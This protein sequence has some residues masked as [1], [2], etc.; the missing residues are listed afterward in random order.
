[1]KRRHLLSLPVAALMPAAAAT[2]SPRFLHVGSYAPLGQGLYS[3]GIAPDGGLTSL[4]LTANAHSPSWLV[5]QGRR[6]YAAEEGADQVAVY[7]QDEAGGLQLQQRLASGGQGPVHLALG[8]G[9]AWVAHYGDARFAALPLG[10]DGRL[11]PAESW[12]ACSGADCRPGPVRAQYGP[13]GSNAISGHDAPHAHMVQ[14]SVDG[15]WLL[16]TDLGRDRLLVWPLTPGTPQGPALELALSPGSGPRH[17]VCHADDPRW[18][19]V[20]Q[21]ESSTLSTVELTPAGPLLRGEI[22]VLPAGFAGT[23]YASDLL[24]ASGG[25]HLYALNR[26]HDSLAVLSLARP[27]AP[28]LLDHHWVHGS[29]PRSACRAGPHLYVCNQ[30]SDQLSH[31]DLSRPER[32]RFTGRQTAV[33]APASACSL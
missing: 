31:F 2:T 27:A 11:G 12:T 26:L 10:A 15:R 25:R 8:A 9:R 30:R 17:F 13:S 32:P 6:V 14:P 24:L 18:V 16:G 29:Y 7:A 1:M 3:F 28:R 22:S 33:P 23:S 21:E 20:L 4:G 5:A 19:Y